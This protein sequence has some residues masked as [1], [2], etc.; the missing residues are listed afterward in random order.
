MKNQ[1]LAVCPMNARFLGEC[2]MKAAIS[3]LE[4]AL[5]TLETNQPINRKEG[6]LAQAD[7]EAINA[8]EIKGAIAILHAVANGPIWPEPVDV[9]DAPTKPGPVG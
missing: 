3:T 4:A 5:H 8:A 2:E 9:T 1:G 6:N 7:L